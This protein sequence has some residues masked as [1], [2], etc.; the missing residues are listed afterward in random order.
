[1]KKGKRNFRMKTNY[2]FLKLL[3]NRILKKIIDEN[4]KIVICDREINVNI[5]V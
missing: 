3:F 2:N 1:M 4:K 5:K